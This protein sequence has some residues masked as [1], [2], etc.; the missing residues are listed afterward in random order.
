KAK[1]SERQREA[2]NPIPATNT[3]AVDSK[4]GISGFLLP[5]NPSPKSTRGSAGEAIEKKKEHR[6]GSLRLL[7]LAHRLRMWIAGEI[8]KPSKAPFRCRYDW[9]LCLLG[10]L[11]LARKSEERLVS[12]QRLPPNAQ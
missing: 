2:V 8:S 6:S 10:Q 3:Q 5:E 7:K 4:T 9:S 12:R 1:P 11:F